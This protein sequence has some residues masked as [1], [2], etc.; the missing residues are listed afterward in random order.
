MG[1]VGASV[2][3]PALLGY[4]H[5]GLDK[6]AYAQDTMGSLMGPIG[7]NKAMPQIDHA[8]VMAFFA[9]LLGKMDNIEALLGWQPS[10]TN[11]PTIPPIATV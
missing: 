7:K 1:S 5:H 3:F 10:T 9:T 11:P 2:W 6:N 4:E 8:M